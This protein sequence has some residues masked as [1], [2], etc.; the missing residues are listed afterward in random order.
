MNTVVRLLRFAEL[1]ACVTVSDFTF[2]RGVS[3]KIIYY[4]FSILD[5][6]N[7]PQG[8]RPLCHAWTG[9]VINFHITCIFFENV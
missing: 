5:S 6:N 3:V 4:S 1:F 8:S 9:K 2:R 7:M